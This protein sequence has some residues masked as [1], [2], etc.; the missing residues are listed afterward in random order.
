[1]YIQLC[2]IC[3]TSLENKYIVSAGFGKYE[4]RRSLCTACGFPVIEFLKDLGLI[5][6]HIL[7]QLNDRERLLETTFGNP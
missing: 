2:D 7:E 5:E 6:S 1:M 3:K 4:M